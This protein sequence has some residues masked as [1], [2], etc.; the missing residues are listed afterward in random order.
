MS[1]TGQTIPPPPPAPPAP[2]PPA[3]PPSTRRNPLNLV[4]LIGGIALSVVAIVLVV[5]GLLAFSSASSARDDAHRYTKERRSLEARERATQG[6]I[7]TVVSEGQKVGDPIDKLIDA[8]NQAVA[9][10]NELDD[11]LKQA[12]DKFN[13]GDE[14]GANNMVN[15]QGK[16]IL[17]DL[18]RLQGIDNQALTAAQ[19][20]QR[21]LRQALI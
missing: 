15:G 10:S 2:L 12:V 4:L 8:E 14:T 20:A 11:L 5:V 21:K 13:A 6:D 3:V 1:N 9:K 19:D 16:Q 17:S 7:D 18:E